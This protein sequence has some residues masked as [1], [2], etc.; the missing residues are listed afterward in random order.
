[1]KEYEII[2]FRH[3]RYYRSEQKILYQKSSKCWKNKFGRKYFVFW[4]SKVK[5]LINFRKRKCRKNQKESQN[6]QRRNLSKNNNNLKLNKKDSRSSKGFRNTGN[7]K[8]L[9]FVNVSNIKKKKTLKNMFPNFPF[10]MM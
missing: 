2:H 4:S 3:D 6:I 7:Y 8:L 1:M 10:L 5:I 9:K